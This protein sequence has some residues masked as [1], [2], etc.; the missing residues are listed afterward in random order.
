MAKTW[1]YSGD[2]PAGMVVGNSNARINGTADNYVNCDDRGTTIS[3][4]VSFVTMPNQIR[5]GGLW[6]MSNIM[7]LSLPSTMATPSP[8]MRVDPP[9]KPFLSL[10]KTTTTMMILCGML[11]SI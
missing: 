11:S 2:S 5:F 4:P 3:G 7:Q 8:V 1:K 6:T 10:M 9:I